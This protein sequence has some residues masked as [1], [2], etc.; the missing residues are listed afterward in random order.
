MS[1]IRIQKANTRWAGL[2][3]YYGIP[4]PKV[5]LMRLADY[6]DELRQQAR[7]DECGK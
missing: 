7:W 5:D 6:I 4:Y 3:L 1:K 2:A